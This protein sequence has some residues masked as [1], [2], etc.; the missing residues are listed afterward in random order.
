LLLL[1]VATYLVWDRIE[2][3]E[4]ARDIAAIAARGEP[5]HVGD[6]Y[7]QPRTPEQREASSLY[8]QAAALAQE[9]GAED[10]HRA[11]RLDLDK[12]GGAE[13]S[14]PDIVAAYR[15]DAPSLQLL[16]RATPLDFAG[17]QETDRQPPGYGLPLVAL[18]ALACLRADLAAVRGDGEAAVAALV[19]CVRLQRTLNW[20]WYRSDHAGRLLGSFRILFRHTQPSDASLVTLQRALETWSDEDSTLGTVLQERAR[21]TDMA[22]SGRREILPPVARFLFHPLWIHGVRRGLASFEPSIVLAHQPWPARWETVEAIN[23]ANSR[24]S[25]TG[26]PGLLSRLRDPFQMRFAGLGLTESARELAAR[27]TAVT[28]IAVERFR[29]AHAGAPPPSL[30]ALVPAFITVVPQD[31]FSGKPLV[32]RT[33]ADDYVIY[34]VDSNRRDDEGSLYG[35][36]AAV[37]KYVGAQS[38][39]DLGIRVPYKPESDWR[40]SRKTRN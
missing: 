16:D 13:L 4:L 37:T 33:G 32:Y 5:V 3:R 34:S 26:R 27:R 2:A 9:Q 14:L 1:L 22:G 6:G 8:A 23:R 15:A 36:G 11:S 20:T 25:P 29:R 7:P 38:P 31:P 21:L 28:V 17:F 30:D 24:L 19:P 39:R 18:G 12:P 40:D 35:H 10:N